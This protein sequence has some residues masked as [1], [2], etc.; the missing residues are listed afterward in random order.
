LKECHQRL[1]QARINCGFKTAAF[2]AE[3]LGIPYGTYS[4]HEN[5]S[6]GIKEHE[7]KKY[8]KVFKVDLEWLAFGKKF[9][10]QSKAIVVGN[11]HGPGEVMTT[12]SVPYIIEIF[13]PFAIEDNTQA[14]VVKTDYYEPF[15]SK[16][17][18]LLIGEKQNI[19]HLINILVTINAQGTYCVGKILTENKGKR[20]TFQNIIGKVFKDLEINYCAPILS[21]IYNDKK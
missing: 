5:G 14:L 6:R 8:A 1:K 2:A 13:P 16:G 3:R 15:L 12:T 4:G 11:V 21:I 20:I 10:Y 19:N 9:R 18:I 7:L 17:D